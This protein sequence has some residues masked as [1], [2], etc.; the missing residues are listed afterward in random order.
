MA[1]NQKY[2]HSAVWLGWSD[3]TEICGHDTI[4]ML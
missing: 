3:F 1:L 4:A 2:I